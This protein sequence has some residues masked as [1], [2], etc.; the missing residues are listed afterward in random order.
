MEDG[1]PS[2]GDGEYAEEEA[3]WEGQVYS[4]GFGLMCGVVFHLIVNRLSVVKNLQQGGLDG[5]PPAAADMGNVRSAAA[6]SANPLSTMSN[7]LS[8]KMVLVVRTDIG[9]GKG[10][11]CAQCAHA[12][13]ACYKDGL[14]KT[15]RFV[16]QWEMFGQTKVTLKADSPETLDTIKEKAERLGLVALEIRD[17]G[18]TQIDPGTV[19][20]LGVG[21]GPSDLVD[22]ITGHLKLY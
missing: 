2:D 5:P 3:W 15:P 17:A 21:P 14:K 10:K 16:K 7:P 22:Q 19:T 4:L 11:A 8:N 12:A 18:R 1:S 9:M 20:V 6:A 13:V